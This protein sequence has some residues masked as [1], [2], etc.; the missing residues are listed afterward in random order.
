M[1]FLL[2][3][4]YYAT[5]GKGEGHEE[6]PGH[7]QPIGSHMDPEPVRTISHLPSP[8]EFHEGFVLPKTPVVIEGALKGSDV[9]KR[10]KHDQY[11]R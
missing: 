5:G 2:R 9:W 8:W 3:L 6:L 1:L 10:W 7:M 11:L 4:L